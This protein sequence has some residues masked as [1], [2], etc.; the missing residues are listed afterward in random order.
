MVASSIRQT[1]KELKAERI[2]IDVAIQKLESILES[3]TEKR[4]SAVTRVIRPGRGRPPGKAKRKNAPRGLLRKTMHQALRATNRALTPTELRDRVMNS[5]YP[6]TSAKIL[7][8]AVYNAAKKDPDIKKT[9]DGFE[10]RAAAR[11]KKK[12]RS[13]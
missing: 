8:T 2:R 1:L 6:A 13:R 10:L 3:L 11:K 12:Q 9:K 5:G 7:Y 4:T